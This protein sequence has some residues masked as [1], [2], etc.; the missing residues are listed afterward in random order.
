[1]EF[2]YKVNAGT[3]EWS[4]KTDDLKDTE[5]SNEFKN[6]NPFIARQEAFERA[7]SYEE[8]FLQAHKIGVGDFFENKN[9]IYK[10]FSVT[11]SLVNPDTFEDIEIDIF[12]PFTED[13]L[14]QE[15]YAYFTMGFILNALEKEVAVLKRHNVDLLN[16]TQKIK[17]LNYNQSKETKIIE[18]VP[19]EYCSSQEIE[20]FNI[21]DFL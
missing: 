1:M 6:E 18:V 3:Y 13:S 8:N 14:M 5:Y 2:I 7:K 17:V 15:R 9:E 21:D 11:I 10:E 16:K 4:E 12:K 20:I 19:T